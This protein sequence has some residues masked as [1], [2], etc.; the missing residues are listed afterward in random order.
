[1]ELARHEISSNLLYCVGLIK[2]RPVK[3][4]DSKVAHAGLIAFGYSAQ[5][6]VIFTQ[7]F[8]VEYDLI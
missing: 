1:M 7:L 5:K 3:P 6:F 4:D 2:K 8:G